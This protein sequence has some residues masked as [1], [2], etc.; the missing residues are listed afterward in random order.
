MARLKLD[1]NTKIKQFTCLH[2]GEQSLTV[3]GYISKDN[4]AYAVYYA[5]LMTGHK[6]VSA[7][8]TISLGGWEKGRMK[9]NED[10]STLKPARLLTVTK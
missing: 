5:N 10:G 6:E 8:L 9:P 7:R 2:C 1:L 3:W 4:L